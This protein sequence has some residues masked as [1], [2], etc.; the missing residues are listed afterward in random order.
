MNAKEGVLSGRRYFY[1]TNRSSQYFGVI[2]ADFN[3]LCLS[4]G[5]ARETS[6]LYPMIVSWFLL[7]MMMFNEYSVDYL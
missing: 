7:Q 3:A 2:V 4:Y 6:H 1:K 5:S